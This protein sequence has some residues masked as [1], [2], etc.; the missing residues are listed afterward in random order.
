MP[1][2]YLQCEQRWT[3][4][5]FERTTLADHGLCVQLGHGGDACKHPDIMRSQLTVLDVNGIHQVNV[6]YCNCEKAI[7]SFE[8]RIQLLRAGWFPATLDRPKTVITFDALDLFHALT[9]QSKITFY[10][11]YHTLVRRTDNSG[12]R[13]V[14][15]R[16][17]L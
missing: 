5:F 14:P 17:N 13:V 3:G 15:V 1:L 10:D 8:R 4:S 7:G 9:L 2:N 16:F 11:F 6:A 12:I